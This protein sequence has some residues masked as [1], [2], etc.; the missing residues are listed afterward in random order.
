MYPRAVVLLLIPTLLL[1]GSFF[2]HSHAADGDH[3]SPKHARKPHFHVPGSGPDSRHDHGPNGHHHPHDDADDAPEPESAPPE[4][5]HPSDH[6]SDAVFV[7]AVDAVAADRSQSE[8]VDCLI[9]W[10]AASSIMVV[11]DSEA[12]CPDRAINY[13][14]PPLIESLYRLYVQDLALLI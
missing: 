14:P 1:Q 5:G 9:V 8:Q 13:H 6:D 2:A 11:S 12:Q 4:P 3:E 7:A 10:T